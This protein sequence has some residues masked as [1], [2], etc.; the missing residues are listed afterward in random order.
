VQA[1]APIATDQ[2]VTPITTQAPV[3]QFA[4]FYAS[5][6]YKE[7]NAQLGDNPIGTMDMYESPYFGMMS[8]G[9]IG[10]AQDRVYEQYLARTQPQ[11]ATQPIA[12]EVVMP[13]IQAASP[14]VTQIIQPVAPTSIAQTNDFVF[15]E[16]P[17]IEPVP[18]LNM[19]RFGFR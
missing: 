17:P 6:E 4:D 5:P 14:A 11:I 2:P 3:N 9:S 1:A 8:S 15:T 10:R 19:P 7:F 16:A 12:P 18:Y 13:A